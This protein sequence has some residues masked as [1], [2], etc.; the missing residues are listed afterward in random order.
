MTG[1]GRDGADEE[2]FELLDDPYAREILVETRDGPQSA[3]TL[4][5]VCDASRST[6]YRRIER[7]REHDLLAGEQR[8]DPKGHHHEV[9]SARLQRVTIE[10]TG[11]GFVVDV[12][13]TETDDPADRF[14]SLYRRLSNE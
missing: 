8:L 12:D 2:L 7:L 4:S 5:E 11:D 9:Y 13:R 6:I 3:D 10:L 14:T 1:G